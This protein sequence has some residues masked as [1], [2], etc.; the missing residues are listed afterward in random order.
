MK[1]LITGSAGFVG[2]HLAKKLSDEGRDLIL[3]DNFARGQMDKNFKALID[4]SNVEFFDLDLT[5]SNALDYINFEISDLYHLAAI[6]GTENFYN[7]PEK[8]LKVNILSTLNILD[9]AINQPNIKILFSSSS[10]VYAG[11]LKMGIGKVPTDENVP[12]CIDDISNVR[13]SYGASKLLA[14]NAFF[15]YSKNHQIN[16]SIIRYHNI[17]G[18]RMGFEHVIPQF[19]ERIFDGEVPLNVFGGNQTSA[20][21]YISD[22]I[23][24]T[25]MVMESLDTNKKIVHIGNDQEEI[26][27]KD[28]A[29]ILL[30]LTGNPTSIIQ[31]NPPEGSVDRRCPNIDFLKTIGFKPK[32]Q[33]SDGLTLTREWYENYHSKKII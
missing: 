7:I 12:L 18:P 14:E 33:L 5:K 19:L 3:I 22:A 24:A 16:F 27:I 29:K 26:K 15:S 30:D 9:W 8:V 11:A 2:Y 13:W 20:F 1:T 6:N 4:K 28:L 25:Q 23:E 10:E 32:I 21:C 17:F 31:K